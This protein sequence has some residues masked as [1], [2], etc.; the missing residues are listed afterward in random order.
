MSTQVHANLTEEQVR[1]ISGELDEPEWLL[2]T[3]LEALEALE[4]LDM[5]DVI[6]TPGRDWT[7]LH[8]LDF[9]SLV[10]PLNAAEN[11][12]QVGPDEVD[13]L[14]WADAVQ[15]HEDLIEDHFGS[16][17][18]PRRTTSLHSRRRCLAPEPSSTSPKESTP[19]TSPSAPS[20]TPARCS[21][22]RSSSPRSRVP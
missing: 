18:D 2:E 10:D 19:R 22:T 8:E 4:E 13:V 6:R 15:E 14:P 3:R 7:N 21:T 17:V 11:K 5:P 20:K 16:I 12:D 9:E 1:Q